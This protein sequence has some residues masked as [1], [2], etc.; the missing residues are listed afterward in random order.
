MSALLEKIRQDIRK[1]SFEELHIL[2]A[3]LNQETCGN[4][5][6]EDEVQ[7]AWD[8]E[9]I[10]RVKATLPNKKLDLISWDSVN[11]TMLTEQ[12]WDEK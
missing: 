7:N 6:C 12:K 3:D 10:L 9:L 5:A 8:E 4:H 11:M 1:L 2:A